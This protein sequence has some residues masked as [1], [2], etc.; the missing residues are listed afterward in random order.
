MF[1][2]LNHSDVAQGD[3]F[4]NLARLFAVFM[5]VLLT[6]CAS[7]P[8]ETVE[9]RTLTPQEAVDPILGPVFSDQLNPETAKDNKHTVL[10]LSAGGADGAFGAGVLAGWS[11][12]GTRPDFDVV[13][14]V[15]TGAL[16]AVLAFLGPQ[17]DALAQELYTTQTNDSIF[18][19]RGLSGLLSDSL[20]DNEPF[21]A[22]IEKH[23]TPTV[24]AQVAAEH[25]KGRRLYVAT[26]NIDAG[27][28]VIWDMGNIAKGG[29]SN[30][31]Q[32]FQKVLRASASVPGFFKPVYIKPKRG[33]QLRQAHVD[34][35]VKEPILFS[36]FMGASTIED[37]E[38]FM[39][40]N[41]TTRRFNSSTPVKANLASITQKTI[42]E[43]MREL[44]RETIYRH[45]TTARDTGMKFNITSIPDDIPI[46]QQSLNFDP[47]RMRKLYD[48]GQRIGVQGVQA[49]AKSPPTSASSGTD[50]R[51][52]ALQ[53]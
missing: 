36:R 43:L 40:I 47:A 9:I 10:A 39:I 14:G 33:V 27:E 51:A 19:K 1:G 6:S 23:I 37:R 7:R 5:V 52:A 26:T 35:G 17:Y 49:W 18:R 16:L 8:N 44:Q 24:L 30:P 15:S 2:V 22:Q 42:A 25:D 46:A 12:S 11:Q 21:K 41:G 48:A 50:K 13:T 3:R 45:Y 28:L 20:Y 38:L 29:R 4:I 53:Q 31:L 34:G 32:H